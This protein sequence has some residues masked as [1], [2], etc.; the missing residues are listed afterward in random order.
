MTA[1]MAYSGAMCELAHEG[2]ARGRGP[3]AVAL[4]EFHKRTRIPVCKEHLDELL[5]TSDGSP[6]HWEPTYLAWIFD[7]HQRYCG[8]HQ[9][10]A[11]LCADWVHNGRSRAQED[12]T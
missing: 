2:W 5:D 11:E 9:W 12:P 4:I 10:P 1:S 7:P 6:S 3:R 8:L